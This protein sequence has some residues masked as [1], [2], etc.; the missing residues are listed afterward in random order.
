MRVLWVTYA[1]LGKGALIIEN[2]YSQSGT[3]IDST[4]N[5]LLK[6]TDIDLGIASIAS[7]DCK[8]IGKGYL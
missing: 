8:I 6:N 4:A 5:E 2:N 3:W 7:H 1:P